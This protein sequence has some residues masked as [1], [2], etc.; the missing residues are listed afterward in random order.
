MNDPLYTSALGHT[1]V[2]EVYIV[3]CSVY[4]CPEVSNLIRRV[5]IAAP[6]N[7]RE[8]KVGLAVVKE[9]QFV[10]LKTQTVCNPNPP[11]YTQLI[12]LLYLRLTATVAM[13]TSSNSGFVFHA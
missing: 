13:E 10:A 12:F 3:L 8:R 11:L 4:T 6:D 5:V 9:T 7:L 2:C 1:R